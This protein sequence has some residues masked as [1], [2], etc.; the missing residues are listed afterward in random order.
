[1]VTIRNSNFIN[2]QMSLKDIS[3]AFERG[4]ETV[5]GY[6]YNTLIEHGYV[7]KKGRYFV[8][9]DKLMEL[10]FV[11]D[12]ITFHEYQRRWL[13]SIYKF[14]SEEVIENAFDNNSHIFKVMV[15]LGMF[16]R[17]QD[18]RY[19]KS[20]VFEDLLSEG[21]STFKLKNDLKGE[22]T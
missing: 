6:T 7:R 2:S 11:P 9:T 14:Y 21:E 3:F 16:K 18:K 12:Q 8:P 13:N 22:E 20:E 15:K 17:E 10:A 1:M 4:K 5:K 19:R